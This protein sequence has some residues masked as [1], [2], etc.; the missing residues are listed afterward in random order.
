[1]RNNNATGWWLPEEI[2][3]MIESFCEAEAYPCP[4]RDRARAA[5]AKVPGIERKRVRLTRPEFAD[6]SRRTHLERSV[7]YFI[8]LALA[9]PWPAPGQPIL[10]EAVR[11]KKRA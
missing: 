2:D 6:L 10:V 5:L 7:V 8:P 11:E 4:A 1:M 3:E 9:K